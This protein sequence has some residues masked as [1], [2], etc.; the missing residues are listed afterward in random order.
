[1]PQEFYAKELQ[2]QTVTIDLDVVNTG[3]RS[4]SDVVQVYLGFPSTATIPQ[5]PRQLKAFAKIVLEPHQTRHV[6]LSLN[7]HSFSYW[8]TSQHA[9]NVLPGKYKI[10]IGSSSSD[11]DM[12]GE[13]SIR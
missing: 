9:W 13:V 1:M 3:K 6:Q 4:G 7:Q 12:Q 8:D 2:G 5:P 10:M 11:A